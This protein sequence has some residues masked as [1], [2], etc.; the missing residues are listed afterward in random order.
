MKWALC[1]GSVFVHENRCRSNELH[2]LDEQWEMLPLP[3]AVVIANVAG[4]ATGARL[5]Q[6]C[7]RWEGF[8]LIYSVA[9]LT[10]Y[11]NNLACSFKL[12]ES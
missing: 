4:D 12:F 5:E 2:H 8:G 11:A 6:S 9:F 7:S 1:D 3:D 10:Q